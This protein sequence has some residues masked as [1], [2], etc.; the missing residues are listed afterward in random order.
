MEGMNMST[1]ILPPG[2][3][4]HPTDEELIAHYLKK[5]VN[6]PT[7]PMVSIIAEIDL[8]K[9][10]PWDL[11]DKAL[12]GES[13]WFFFTPRDRKYPNGARPNRAA[14]S[15]YWKATGTDKPIISSYGSQCVGVKKALVFYG[16]RPPK[17]IKTDWMMY[18]YRLLDESRH[19]MRVRGSMRLDDW[20]LCR[21]RQKSNIPIPTKDSRESSSSNNNNNKSFPHQLDHGQ[22]QEKDI[23]EK[24]N[25]LKDSDLMVPQ[26]GEVLD[27]H[28]AQ[29]DF[30]NQSS[31]N[32][33]VFDINSEIQSPTIVSM[34][35]ALDKIKRVLSIGA[36]DEQV[37]IITPNKRLRSLNYTNL[38]KSSIFEISWNV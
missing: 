7:S 19:S 34:K 6:S 36:M 31:S 32:D 28:S 24:M 2:F 37:P 8:Y 4:F 33:F 22:F 20:V 26:E 15:G 18:E 14:A 11:P 29:L 13:E 27:E 12:F 1:S 10:N 38:D 16:G 23:M 17:G 3:R 25:Y 5:K 21:V 30:Q 35:A 9:F